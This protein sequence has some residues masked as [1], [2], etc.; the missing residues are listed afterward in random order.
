[1]TTNHTPRTYRMVKDKYLTQADIYIGDSLML[2]GVQLNF[3]AHVVRSLNTEAATTELLE[4][5][6]RILAAWG[7]LEGTGL[8]HDAQG[9]VGLALEAAIQKAGGGK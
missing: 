5:A 2:K 7:K 8:K 6:K 4:A 3:A 9:N 1:M